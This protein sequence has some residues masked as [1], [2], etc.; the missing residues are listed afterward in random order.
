MRE[1]RGQ[2]SPGHHHHLANATLSGI[3]VPMQQRKRF[4]KPRIHK[5]GD[6]RQLTR[7]LQPQGKGSSAGQGAQS[8]GYDS[9]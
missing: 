5:F 1:E 4:R 6:V 3:L 2:S 8:I 7:L 9:I